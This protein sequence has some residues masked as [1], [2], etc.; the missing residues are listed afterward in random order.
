MQLLLVVCISGLLMR[1]MQ[2]VVVVLQAFSQTIPQARSS[3][4]SLVPSVCTSAAP[5]ARHPRRRVSFPRAQLVRW[6]Y[7]PTAAHRKSAAH[8]HYTRI[9]TKGLDTYTLPGHSLFTVLQHPLSRFERP[10]VPPHL[11]VV[12]LHPRLHFVCHGE[13]LLP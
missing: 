9:H 11:S 13:I 3:S 4:V 2:L 10:P 8:Q 7:P 6:K 5:G 12:L 1:R